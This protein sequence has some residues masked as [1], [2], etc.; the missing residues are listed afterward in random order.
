MR[1][2]TAPEMQCPLHGARRPRI[3]RILVVVDA[4]ARSHPCVEKAARIA[5]GCGAI[6]ELYVCDTLHAGDT[7]ERS[8]REE[9]ALALLDA[10]AGPLRARDLSVQCHTEWHAPL[11]QG[12]GLRVLKSGADFVV[13]DTHRH[14]L[15]PVRGGYGLTD[16][17]LIRQIPVPLLLV[18]PD[19]WPEHPRITVGVDPLHPAR[20]PESLDEEMIALGTELAHATHGAVDAL[21]VLQDPPHLPGE[22][23]ADTERAAAHAA[24]RA[25]VNQL[26]ERC[27]RDGHAVAVHFVPGRIV[28]GVLGFATE[29]RTHIVVMG[30]G[31]HSRWRGTGASGA[32]AEILESLP[33]DLLVV[34][35]PG[36]VSPLLVTED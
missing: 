14:P 33:C 12:V 21:H 11:E 3:G 32:A 18:R 1:L 15:A 5:A 8:A 4:G 9:R 23:V 24:A 6:L 22:A 27:D 19:P 10:L 17:T 16:W 36:Y 28:P 7:A 2:E 20:R 29:H 31:A 34:R 25:Q 13:K 26:L 35:P 30:S